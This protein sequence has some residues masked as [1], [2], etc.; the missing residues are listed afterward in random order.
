MICCARYL[1]L[2]CINNY[3]TCQ[4]LGLFIQPR[5]GAWSDKLNQ[6]IPFVVLLSMTALVGLI[7]LMAA[8]PLTQKLGTSS[9]VQ[10]S[11][12]ESTTTSIS[13][14]A[15]V[16][17]FIGF[18]LADICFDCLL[19]PGRALLND[20]TTT[21]YSHEVTNSIFTGLQLCGRLIALFVGSSSWT[22]SGLWGLYT[23]DPHFNACLTI[24]AVY[25]L[26]SMIAVVLFVDDKGATYDTINDTINDE[27]EE[28]QIV[29][30]TNPNLTINN[31]SCHAEHGT[32]EASRHTL[33]ASVLL[34]AVQAVGWVGICA[35]SFFWTSWREEEVG[36]TDLA[37]QSIVGLLSAGC[38]PKANEHFG[39]ARVWLASELS[40][41]LLLMSS[42]AWKSPRVLCALTGINY[43][44]HQ[45]NGLIV[46]VDIASDPVA[47]RA[48]IIAMV[49]NTLPMGQLVVA[50]F[51]GA[52]AQYF[53]GFTYV[54]VCFGSLG[55]LVTSAVWIY[56]SKY[57]LM[58][59]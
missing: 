35:L 1:S 47:N 31:S 10:R 9:Y 38:L 53:G 44:I 42:V 11:G 48:S 29:H 5:I 15:I 7:I 46:A 22:M 49:N 39:A 54:F 58:R 57:D 41:H 19:I 40:F 36:C 45:T 43:T 24:S 18:G 17:A 34:C 13:T 56:A 2:K 33:D 12:E 26:L 8:V 16:L 30:Q 27:E 59:I 6:R 4:T 52:I 55:A 3:Q 37:I 51:G 50:V 28:L 25:I 21:G 23:S 32:S 14:A 20:M